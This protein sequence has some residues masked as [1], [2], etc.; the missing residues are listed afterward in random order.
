MPRGFY[1]YGIKRGLATPEDMKLTIAARQ[2]TAQTLVNGGMSQRQAAKA[3]GVDPKTIRND[4]GK[5][6]P[7]SGEKVPTTKP[8]KKSKVVSA[9]DPIQVPHGCLEVFPVPELARPKSAHA[10][11][12]RQRMPEAPFPSAAGR[13]CSPRRRALGSDRLPTRPSTSFSACGG[14]FF[15]AS[16]GLLPHIIADCFRINP[17]APSPACL[18][19][20][21]AVNKGL[22]RLLPRPRL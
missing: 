9:D 12:I 17:Q 5:K 8:K 18:W 19:L 7:G 1:D 11:G 22:S 2:K 4:V 21:P 16:R 6:S 20:I 15:P 13:L 10:T 3:L 14:D